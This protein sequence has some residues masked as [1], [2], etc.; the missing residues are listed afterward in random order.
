[1]SKYNIVDSNIIAIANGLHDVASLK[2]VHDAIDFLKD[3]EERISK[4]ECL[5]VFDTNY[6]ILNEYHRHCTKFTTQ[7][8]GTVFYKWVIRNIY[9]SDK[10]LLEEL[11]HD[12]ENNDAI[13]PACFKGFDRNDKKY[14]FFG[15]KYKNHDGIIHYGIDRGYQNFSECFKAEN[16]KLNQ[17]CKH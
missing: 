4:N 16:I 7:K 11:P 6:I 2:C 15:L 8:L 10:F 14:L 5:L 17:I 12:I 3:M 1:M 9:H 13:F